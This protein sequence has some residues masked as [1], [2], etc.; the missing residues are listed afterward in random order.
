MKLR[1]SLVFTLIFTLLISSYPQFAQANTPRS[2]SAESL[3]SVGGDEMQ[4]LF[5]TNVFSA[6]SEEN[7]S[8]RITPTELGKN[9]LG[10]EPWIYYAIPACSS[11]ILIGCIEKVEY[12]KSNQSWLKATL[13]TKEIIKRNGQISPGGRNSSGVISNSEINE[14]PADLVNHAPAAG[15]ASYWNFS[16]APHGGGTDYLLRVNIAGV[17]SAAPTWSNGKVQ[18]Y[19]EMGI[20]PVDGFTEYQFPDDL[21][22]KVRLKL[23]PIAK[24]LWGWF[25]GRVINPSVTLDVDSAD[26]IVEI[27]GE[28]S[29]TPIGLTPKKKISEI[30][31]ELVSIFNCPAGLPPSMCPS[32]SGLKWFSTD[33]NAEVA[34]FAK[35]E[36]GFGSIATAGVKSEWWIKT[37]RWPDVATVRDCPS[38]QNGFTGIVTTN[39]TMYGTAAPTWDPVDKSFSF[40]V[41]SPHFGVNGSPNRGYY[42]L[43]LPKSLAECRWGKN[44]SQLKIVVSIV[45]ADGDINVGTSN[46]TVKNNLLTF[47][48]AGF[49]YSS[50][51]IKVGLAATPNSTPVA[52]STPQPTVAKKITITCMKGK[53]IKKVTSTNPTCPTGYKKK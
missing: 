27:A 43:V 34:T 3:A 20:F 40:Q 52:K 13:S 33:G 17:N 6:S 18:R 49:T 39:A 48:I 14:W 38:E 16:Q 44:I 8:K 21:E 31:S 5:G 45:Y 35:F 26:G 36:K 47:N 15:R 25:D 19:L 30:G 23:G 12:K 50:P 42:S 46:Y 41:A 51:T 4:A 28:P 11:S 10:N 9:I 7:W 53:T 2:W 32:K 1:T 24:D 37:T 29:K 22:I